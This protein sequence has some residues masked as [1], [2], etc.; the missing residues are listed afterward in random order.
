MPPVLAVQ[1]R[2]YY[3]ASDWTP[4]KLDAL[5]PMPETMSLDH[6]R[7]KGAQPDETIMAEEEAD[8]AKK[9][10]AAAPPEADEA[11]VAQ[12][13][14]MGFSENGSRRAAIAVNNA[15]AEHAV[16]WV[17]AHMEDAD[18]NDPPSAAAATTTNGAAG[19]NA[20]S[21]AAADASSTAM[22]SAMGFSDAHARTALL[23]LSLIHI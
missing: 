22:L 1:V 11:I 6:L 8:A 5:V 16:E 21:N 17:F 19:S 20:G 10:E 23:A 13:M 4:K 7:A 18:F 3:V 9:S 2:R 15:S 12:V 14:S